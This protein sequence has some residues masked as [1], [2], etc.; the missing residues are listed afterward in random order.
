MPYSYPSLI[1][2]R[3]VPITPI[4]QMKSMVNNDH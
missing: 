2:N 3:T 4:I 1:I